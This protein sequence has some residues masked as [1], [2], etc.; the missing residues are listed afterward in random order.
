M[1]SNGPPFIMKC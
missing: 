1:S